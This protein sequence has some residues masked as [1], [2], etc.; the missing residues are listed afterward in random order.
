[1]N[2]SDKSSK[3]RL[4]IHDISFEL[5]RKNVK[6][7][8]LRVTAPDGIVKVSAPKRLSLDLIY[9]FVASKYDW[10]LLQQEKLHANGSKTKFA[11][12]SGEKHFYFDQQYVLKCVHSR[13]KPKVVLNKYILKLYIDD[14]STR[15]QRQLIIESWYRDQLK[16]QISSLIKKYEGLMK[17]EV[18]EFGVKK[19][20]TR[21]GTC[22][23][24]AKRIWLNLELAKKPLEC[25]E[26]VV[27]HEMSHFLESN[28][29]QRFYNIVA[30]YMPQWKEAEENLS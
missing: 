14:Q 7:I 22:N 5:T 23:P 28:H 27:L 6:N 24:R 18:C 25:L 21:W 30:K 15:E 16:N 3:M 1:M 8:N 20:K 4:L 2:K 12:K 19:M 29:N 13:I 9:D 17:L 10:I 11:Y 26:Y